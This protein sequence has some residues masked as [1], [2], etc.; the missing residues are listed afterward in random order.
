MHYYLQRYLGAL[1]NHRHWLWLALLPAALYLLLAAV[2][3]VVYEVTQDFTGW[4]P[5]TPVAASNSPM[6]TFKLAR[7]IADPSLLLLDGA[8]LTQL[9]NRLRLLGNHP[10][11]TEES[12]LHHRI[13]DTMSLT[14]QDAGRLRLRYQGADVR[15]GQVLVGFYSD[16]LLKR[17]ADGATRTRTPAAS[18]PSTLEPAGAMAVTADRALWRPARLLPAAV[19]VLIAA[20]AIMA[21]IAWFEAS[22]PSFR[23][24]RQIARYLDV[25]VLGTLPNAEPLV[26]ALPK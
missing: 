12:A 22:D 7:L 26:R 25:P 13:N 4:S 24:E 19:I 14:E 23:S 18:A 21:L 1:R 17:T 2:T 5:N 16:R 9:Q 3:D 15:L 6:A 20:L 10:R 8:A 11:L